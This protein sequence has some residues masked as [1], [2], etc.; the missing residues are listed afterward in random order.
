MPRGFTLS[1]LRLAAKRISC[2]DSRASRSVVGS[3]R[4]AILN[5]GGSSGS[6]P[7]V[8]RNDLPFDHLRETPEPLGQKVR[9]WSSPSR[10][11]MLSIARALAQGRLPAGA[12]RR[13]L[14]RRGEVVDELEREEVAALFDEHLEPVERPAGEALDER[15][16][17][18]R[19]ELAALKDERAQVV[20]GVLEVPLPCGLPRRKAREDLEQLAFPDDA[21][22]LVVVEAEEVVVGDCG[23]AGVRPEMPA[24]A[25]V[26]GAE[27]DVSGT[28]VAISSS[29]RDPGRRLRRI[30]DHGPVQPGHLDEAV[31]VVHADL[32]V[33]ALEVGRQLHRERHPPARARAWEEDRSPLLHR[34]GG[35]RNVTV[36][37][38][39]SATSPSS[40]SNGRPP[41]AAMAPSWFGPIA[42]AISWTAPARNAIWSSAARARPRPSPRR[43]SNGARRAARRL[44]PGRRRS[45]RRAP[46][47]SASAAVRR[48]AISALAATSGGG[49]ANQHVVDQLGRRRELGGFGSSPPASAA[50]AGL[51]PARGRADERATVPGS[52]RFP[53]QTVEQLRERGAAGGPGDLVARQVVVLPAPAPCFEEALDVRRIPAPRA[54]ASRTASSPDCRISLSA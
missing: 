54:P 3:R 50:V 35:A 12:E 41:T 31:L 24:S 14:R 33:E 34:D 19:I 18:D 22:Q 1:T 39:M 40:S 38:S 25:P 7:A 20:D 47:A 49:A 52:S 11:L 43:G 45:P 48:R 42:T 51:G 4:T 30:G 17:D 26:A 16:A 29:I 28:I 37:S 21:A 23:S 5:P 44:R 15:L 27:V 13:V 9:G 2:G 53:P 8:L 32:G 36:S 46:R 10:R 6:A